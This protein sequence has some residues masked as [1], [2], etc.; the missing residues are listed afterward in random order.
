MARRFKVRPG[1]RVLI[2]GGASGLGRALAEACAKRGARLM[3]A[4]VQSCDEAV[5]GLGPRT[6]A[7]SVHCD[8][9]DPESVAAMI[10]RCEKELGGLDLLFNNAGVAAAGPLDKSDLETWEWIRSI[11]L[12]G[13][14]YV[15]R[16][17]IPLMRRSGRGWMVNT[18]SLAAFAQAPHMAYYN[19]CKAGVVALSETLYS[20][21][22]PDGIGVSALCPGFFQTNLVDTFRTT[23]PGQRVFVEKVMKKSK[24]TAA[25][26]ADLTLKGIGRG[27]LYILPP[28][29][30]KQTW[31]FSR[32][33]PRLS[34][35]LVTRGLGKRNRRNSAPPSSSSE[36]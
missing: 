19:V 17:A 25:G 27:D 16:A 18:A 36:S 28:G 4:D 14:M 31:Y 2:T 29:T 15:A 8:V 35:S 7:H 12:D 9:S 13:P 10:N 24:L 20:E 30:A 6:E 21:L 1:T 22:E 23:H 34:R 33:F 3:L 5:A 32:F 26:V 11:D